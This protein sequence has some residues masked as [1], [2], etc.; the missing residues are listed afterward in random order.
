VN[1]RSSIIALVAI[2]AI[3]LGAWLSVRFAGSPVT[4]GT[5]T[6][7]K[8]ALELP[9]FS[10]LDHDAQPVGRAVFSG[11]W[12]LVFFGFTHCPDIC[13]LT[14]QVLANARA[15]L[16]ADGHDPLPRIVLVS[17]DPERDTPD[18][19]REY[20]GYFGEGVLGITGELAEI[21]K[22]TDG[23]GVY[24]EKS[25][26]SAAGYSVDHSAIV[27]LVNPDGAFEALFGTPHKPENFV[28]DLPLVMSGS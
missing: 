23:L 1:P 21:R 5:A 20:V 3:A 22:L 14:L 4:P 25:D 27:M 13:P 16:A 12:D 11:Q 26:I 18:V 7:L 10:L 19:L 9:E 8:P 24:F 6:I 17:V 28:Q 15:T 2:A